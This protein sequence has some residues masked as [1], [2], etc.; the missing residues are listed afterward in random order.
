MKFG[1]MIRK[2]DDLTKALE[3]AQS[4]LRPGDEL[5]QM[6]ALKVSLNKLW[7]L[8]EKYW[9]TR[10][11]ISWL[12]GGDKNSRFFHIITKQRRQRNKIV[13]LKNRDEK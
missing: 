2:I 7:E 8:E 9:Q 4:N 12:K 5:I 3:S 11:R 10:S 13:K 1:N 6:N